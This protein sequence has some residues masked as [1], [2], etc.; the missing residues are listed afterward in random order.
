MV[1][2]SEKKTHDDPKQDRNALI[3]TGK[4]IRSGRGIRLEPDF[5]K[6]MREAYPEKSIIQSLKEAGIDPNLV[7]YNRINRLERSFKE[8][9]ETLPQE[10]EAIDIPPEIVEGLRNNPYISEV[11]EKG[12]RLNESFF[13]L[14]AILGELPVDEV[15]N[16]FYVAPDAVPDSQKAS[17]AARLRCSFSDSVRMKPSRM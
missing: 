1:S 7:G 3:S 4:F 14:A 17:I 13:S 15:L 16:V 9:G 10:S 12:I 11:T 8:D 6:C 5:E 2:S